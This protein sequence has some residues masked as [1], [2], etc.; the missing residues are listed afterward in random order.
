MYVPTHY[1]AVTCLNCRTYYCVKCSKKWHQGPCDED[2]EESMK[3]WLD[4]QDKSTVRPCPVCNAVIERKRGCKFMTCP[5]EVCKGN[6]F[7]CMCCGTQ[8]ETKHGKHECTVE[9]N[10]YRICLLM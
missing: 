9:G 2:D 1:K 3:K 8:V 7:F 5:S 10:D 4:A 6:T